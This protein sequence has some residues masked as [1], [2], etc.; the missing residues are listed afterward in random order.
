VIVSS[1]YHI[2]KKV[3]EQKENPPEVINKKLGL[4]TML[5]YN[6]KETL[7]FGCSSRRKRK[8]FGAVL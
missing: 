2:G 8:K 3:F 7:K 6:R 4:I 5:R 1:V